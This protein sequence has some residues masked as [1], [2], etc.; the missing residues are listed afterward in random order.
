MKNRTIKKKVGKEMELIKRTLL[1]C[2]YAA[3][4]TP[5]NLIECF[6]DYVDGGS[7]QGLTLEEAKEEV[8]E[9][10]I[11]LKAICYNLLSIRG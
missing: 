6:Y 1:H 2:G 11:T 5:E 9:G 8:E 7:F 4:P 10:E 3:E